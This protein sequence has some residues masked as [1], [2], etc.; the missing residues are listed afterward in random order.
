M[1][2]SHLLSAPL[3]CWSCQNQHLGQQPEKPPFQAPLILC[4]FLPTASY[5]CPALW[6][7]QGNTKTPLHFSLCT[8]Q[9]QKMGV[10]MKSGLSLTFTIRQA[11]DDLL[12]ASFSRKWNW[13]FHLVCLQ[14]TVWILGLR[15]FQLSKFIVK[16]RAQLPENFVSFGNVRVRTSISKPHHETLKCQC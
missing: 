11:Y 9:V 13:P 8:L 3:Q 15:N 4:I 1:K 2:C 7:T 14:W 6:P 12:P 10:P 16:H 5:L